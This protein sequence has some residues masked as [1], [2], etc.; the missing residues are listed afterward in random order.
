MQSLQVSWKSFS[1]VR[2]FCSAMCIWFSRSWGQADP[3]G[4]VTATEHTG[5]RKHKWGQS[6][7]ACGISTIVIWKKFSLN[8]EKRH[9]W[10]DLVSD[11]HSGQNCKELK[12]KIPEVTETIMIIKGISPPREECL[13]LCHWHWAPLLLPPL[14]S[15]SCRLVPLS[16]INSLFLL[17]AGLAGT[18][19]GD[20]KRQQH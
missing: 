4:A 3:Q 11:V 10:Q 13:P 8:E 12:P 6:I 16:K 18:R 2:R 15:H 20:K 17:P 5:D 19:T 14:L 7:S 1:S 9:D